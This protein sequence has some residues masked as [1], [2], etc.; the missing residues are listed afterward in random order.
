MK[1]CDEP[2]TPGAYGYFRDGA[3]C[4]IAAS[5]TIF[6]LLEMH[7]RV[8]RRRKFSVAWQ[9]DTGIAGLLINSSRLRAD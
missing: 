9:R 5:R 4:I 7:G 6:D 3:S 2:T 1:I 8:A